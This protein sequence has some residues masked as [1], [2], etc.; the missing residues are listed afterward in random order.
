MTRPG[1]KNF[2]TL[3]SVFSFFIVVPCAAK[4]ARPLDIDKSN[5]VRSSTLKPIQSSR[6]LSKYIFSKLS[7]LL[8]PAHVEVDVCLNRLGVSL[9]DVL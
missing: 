1:L 2:L 4:S 5:A 7:S 3:K 9:Y 6:V 8:V